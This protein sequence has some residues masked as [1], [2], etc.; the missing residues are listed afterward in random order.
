MNKKAQEEMVGFAM[1]I[2]IV[3]VILLVLLGI[4]LSNKKTSGVESYEVESFIQA[5]L[6]HTSDCSTDYGLSYD[7]IG[8]LIYECDFT[9]TC[10]DGRSACDALNSTLKN[11]LDESWK[12]GQDRPIKGYVMNITYENHNLLS[13]SKGNM[14]SNYEGSS[15]TLPKRGT[16][17]NIDFKA[18]Y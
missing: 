2:I 16:I 8:N 6:Q 11:I 7:D 1:I 13:I 5:V 9:Q 18:Y 15:Q 4:S 17:Y 12:T 14:T 3:A 10:E